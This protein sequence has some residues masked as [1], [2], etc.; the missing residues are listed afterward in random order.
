MLF[1]QRNWPFCTL[2]SES[3]RIQHLDHPIT[4]KLLHSVG[5][6]LKAR[7]DRATLLTLSNKIKSSLLSYQCRQHWAAHT[8]LIAIQQQPAT[9]LRNQYIGLT[10]PVTWATLWPLLSQI[11]NLFPVTACRSDLTLVHLPRTVTEPPRRCV[12]FLSAAASHLGAAGKGGGG[13]EILIVISQA[14]DL[15]SIFR[16]EPYDWGGSG[17]FSWMR[18]ETVVSLGPR[19]DAEEYAKTSPKARLI[20]QPPLLHVHHPPLLL[21]LIPC[22]LYEKM[23]LSDW[24][25]C[26]WN[27]LHHL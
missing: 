16:L 13:K 8:L 3:F 20:I 26:W 4:L 14:N 23:P 15:W 6:F 24:I 10:S 22:A 27:N 21:I 12:A 19:C 17:P 5:R 25:V 1:P 18:N 9:L 11:S 7:L 2:K